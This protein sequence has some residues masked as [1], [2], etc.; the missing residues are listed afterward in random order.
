KNHLTETGMGSAE[1]TLQAEGSTDKITAEKTGEEQQSLFQVTNIAAGKYTIEAKYAGSF[2]E[3][4]IINLEA[5]LN[6][7]I[8]SD[9]KDIKLNMLKSES[10]G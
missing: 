8:S 2:D 1:V 6:T 4:D 9:T 7:D 10:D 5:T 3:N